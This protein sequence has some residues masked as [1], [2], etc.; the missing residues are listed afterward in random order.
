MMTT[1]S[2]GSFAGESVMSRIARVDDGECRTIPALM[3]EG[4]IL[5][6]WVIELGRACEV[7]RVSTSAFCLDLID[8]GRASEWPHLDLTRSF[9]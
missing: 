1:V 5:G 3:L 8:N 6:P 2:S 7:L 9:G 4:K